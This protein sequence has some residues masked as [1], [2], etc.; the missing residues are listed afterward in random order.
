MAEITIATSLVPG[1]IELQRVAIDSWLKLG[2]KVISLNS[3]EEIDLLY[4]AFPEISFEP[5]LRTALELTGKPYVFFDDILDILSKCESNICGIINSDIQLHAGGE[6]VEF[7]RSNAETDF[8]YASRV[9]IGDFTRHDG[10]FYPYGFDLFFFPKKLILEYPASN[11]C[12]GVPWWDYWALLLPVAKGFAVKELLS[13]VAFHVKHESRWQDTLHRSFGNHLLNVAQSSNLFNASNDTLLK[14]L[15]PACE[16]NNFFLASLLY[17]KYFQQH[18]EQVE[19]E[20]RGAHDGFFAKQ[21]VAIRN[22]LVEAKISIYCLSGELDRLRSS[23]L[24]AHNDQEKELKNIEG[25]NN[26]K[27]EADHSLLGRC[28][29][30]GISKFFSML[31]R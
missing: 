22:E 14:E 17:L 19:V 1:N 27:E 29:R 9:D 26:L 20:Q 18:T 11:F 5:A 21:Y 30:I 28:L 13:P 25:V 23:T 31:K 8:L 24:M 6:F 16:E 3:K 7:V 2:F 4:P 12:L 15:L 10:E